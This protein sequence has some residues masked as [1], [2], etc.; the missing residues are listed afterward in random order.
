MTVGE[1][2]VR[3]SAREIAEWWAYDLVTAEDRAEDELAA[4][5]EAGLRA[6]R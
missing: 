4:K 6:R 1:L 3:M 5:A 2:G